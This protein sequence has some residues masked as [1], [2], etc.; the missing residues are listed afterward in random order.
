M[1]SISLANLNTIFLTNKER[2]QRKL[3]LVTIGQLNVGSG[4]I[5][6]C[7]PIVQ[8]DRAP[9]ARQVAPGCYK[10]D[11]IQG[12]ARPALLVLWLRER[13]AIDPKTLNW[14][15][16]LLAGQDAADLGEDEFYGYP[17]DAGWGCFM[18]ADAARV[19]AE[20]EAR[21][22]AEDP[23]YDN[24]Y[25]AF[26][27][28]DMGQRQ[29]FE[30]HP[31]DDPGACNVMLCTAGWGDGS[32]PSYWALDKQGE[33]V[34]LVTDFGVIE[35]G[36]A[37]DEDE[38]AE[39][40][41]LAS[42]SPEKLVALGDLATAVAAGDADAAAKLCAGGLVSANEIIPSSGETAIYSAIRL[43]QQ[44]VLAALLAGGPCPDMPAQI[45]C[46]FSPDYFAYA[47]RM[48]QFHLRKRKARTPESIDVLRETT[49]VG[50]KP[51][52]S[53]TA[54]SA[55]ALLA[56]GDI[57]LVPASE[58]LTRY[59]LFRLHSYSSRHAQNP[60]PQIA[61]CEGNLTLDS[62][63]L[64]FPEDASGS[65]VVGFLVTGQLTVT[66]NI[67]NKNTDG[68]RSLVVLGDLR[69]GNIAIGDQSLLVRGDLVVDGVHCG[70]GKHGESC[71]DGDV[72]ARLLIADDDYRF[73]VGGKTC[74]AMAEPNGGDVPVHFVLVEECL[75]DEAWPFNFDVF[76]ERLHAGLPLLHPDCFEGSPKL[77]MWRKRKEFFTDAETDYFGGNYPRAVKRYKQAEA[78]GCPTALCRYKRALCHFK[79]NEP[80]EAIPLLTWCIDNNAYLGD[81]LVK[82]AASQMLRLGQGDEANAQAAYDAARADC[83]RVIEAK[84]FGNERTLAEALNILG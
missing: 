17:V 15:M 1:P 28:S 34:A 84:G 39:E 63:D 29:A 11:Y 81:C 57:S 60:Q 78:A 58:V 35:N 68:A 27:A 43:D 37:R 4:A 80:T 51:S 66:G 40:A 25:E 10:V 62:L 24:Y 75:G 79:N 33:P 38:I 7:D 59:S 72:S 23:D 56:S 48:R 30:H 53:V 36:D 67:S 73:H 77:A 52:R 16:A 41:Y 14:E 13:K 6:A 20:R 50:E 3:K 55:A 44:A 47:Q 9:F 83:V 45:K 70:S 61:V 71:V 54:F 8:P 26:L 74:A 5:V 22:M 42:L 69:A 2:T 31:S 49:G 82:R 65:P 46:D 18:D 32:Y 19:M 12:D 21:A 64:D 76:F